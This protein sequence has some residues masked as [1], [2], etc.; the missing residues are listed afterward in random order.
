MDSLIS[1]TG[2]GFILSAADTTSARSIVVMKHDLDKI[3]A[4]DNNKM[5]SIAGDSG[6]AVAFSQLVR[7]NVQLNELQSGI[8]MSTSGVANFT[9]NI[10]AT[11]LRQRPY[12]VQVLLAGVD[13]QAGPALYFLDY[14]G[15]CHPVKYGAHGY[16]NYFVLATLDRYWKPGM[17]LEA[18]KEVMRACIR[19]IQLRLLINQPQFKFK[20][21]DEN[22][23]REIEV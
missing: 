18:V 10:L 15:T 21:V 23:V 13:P 5:I 9:R 6:D 4:I 12:E 8:T 3:V 1:I 16:A 7:A 17:D 20:I 22:G 19:E 2:D 14:L 11:S